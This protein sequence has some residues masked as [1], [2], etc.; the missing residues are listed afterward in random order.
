MFRGALGEKVTH[1]DMLAVVHTE[2]QELAFAG[3][4]L[5]VA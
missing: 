4:I 5:T 1:F 2:Q 3:S